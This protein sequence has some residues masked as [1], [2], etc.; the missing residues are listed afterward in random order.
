MDGLILWLQWLLLSCLSPTMPP[1]VWILHINFLCSPCKAETIIRDIPIRF[2]FQILFWVSSQHLPPNRKS[3]VWWGRA[4]DMS[5]E[6]NLRYKTVSI[7]KEVL[8]EVLEDPQDFAFFGLRAS[9][10]DE[11]SK[12]LSPHFSL[13]TTFLEKRSWVL[14]DSYAEDLQV[15]EKMINY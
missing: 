14:S 10:Q 8:W 11:D 12:D 7:R 15:N 2:L 5:P 4:G 9:D 13:L 1:H 6:A 3:M